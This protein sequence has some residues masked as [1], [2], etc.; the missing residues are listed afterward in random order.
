L[1][2][3][4]GLR[5]A[6]QF[7]SCVGHALGLRLVVRHDQDREP[8]G[9]ERAHERFDGR[10]RF[11]VERG[12]RLVEQQHPRI[13]RQRAGDGHAC[14]LAAGQ[15]TRLAL[16]EARGEA[17]RRQRVGQ[18]GNRRVVQPVGEVRAHVAGQH[19]RRL[20][21]EP[22]PPAQLARLDLGGVAA[23]DQHAPAGRLVEPHQ[24]AQQA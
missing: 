11:A 23:V 6:A 8:A 12:G 17:R 21:H 16:H 10:R 15:R 19:D 2:P 9:G 22:D 20:R 4:P 24:A 18:R 7:E 3:A 5:P 1:R 13:A 14:R